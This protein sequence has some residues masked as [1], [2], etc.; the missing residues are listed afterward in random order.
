MNGIKAD[1]KNIDYWHACG[2]P[3]EIADLITEYAIHYRPRKPLPPPYQ[4]IDLSLR[5]LVRARRFRE[6][7]EKNPDR[8]QEI[9]RH[10]GT[11]EKSIKSQGLLKRLF[12]ALPDK[13]HYRPYSLIEGIRR[14]KKTGHPLT[15]AEEKIEYKK[16]AD[17][18]AAVLEFLSLKENRYIFFMRDAKATGGDAD[19]HADRANIFETMRSL[20][21][22][23]QA[24]RLIDPAAKH[25]ISQ[26][27]AESA[28]M[29]HYV[30][31]LSRLNRFLVTPRHAAIA[32]LAN[33]N[34]L[35]YSVTTE[36][37]KKRW[38]RGEDKDR[39]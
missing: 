21:H 35:D 32:A 15:V 7:W 2:F 37:I 3:T 19:Y 31:E 29:T 16:A 11:L 14:H 25:P 1:E 30:F 27:D 23:E 9:F 18:L 36:A 13:P 6:Y 12:M 8:E 4:T 28:P 22:L 33:I 20:G 5:N 39:A 34:N 24:L 26:P 10:W 17:N 38:A